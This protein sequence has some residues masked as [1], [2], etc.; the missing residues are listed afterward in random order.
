MS[1]MWWFTV[2]G[3]KQKCLLYRPSACL[4]CD[5]GEV[6]SLLHPEIRYPE[7]EESRRGWSFPCI[8][9]NSLACDCVHELCFLICFLS[10]VVEDQ[11]YLLRGGR[12]PFMRLEILHYS[13]DSLLDLPLETQL[14]LQ[15]KCNLRMLNPG[16]VLQCVLTPSTN[17][18]PSF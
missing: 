5:F 16:K 17:S 14:P 12:K 4:A 15:L 18:R 8:C 9:R 3:Q 2:E 7:S 11:F 6:T 13:R 10:E 1:R